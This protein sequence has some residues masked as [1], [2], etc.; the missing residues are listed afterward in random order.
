[1]RMEEEEEEEKEE[2]EDPP[3]AEDEAKE[4]EKS[5]KSPVALYGIRQ[6]PYMDFFSLL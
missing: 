3:K 5:R 2:E 1:M 4:R 6:L